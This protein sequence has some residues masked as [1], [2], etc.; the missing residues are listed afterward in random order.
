MTASADGG[1]KL[2][3][4]KWLP[5]PMRW[6]QT[7]VSWGQSWRLAAALVPRYRDRT[8]VH[9]LAAELPGQ[10]D[11]LV[12][13]LPL[14]KYLV[15]RSPELAR[16]ILVTNQDNWAKSAEYDMMAVTFGQGLVTDMDEQRYQRN[17]R[18]VRPIF[19]RT[20]IDQFAEP[21][22]DAAQDA[23]A[24]IQQLADTGQTV[25]IG[26]EMNRLMLDIVARTMFGTDLSGP[27]SKIS[28]TRLLQFYG[29][30]FSSGLSRPLRALSTWVVKHTQPPE[31]RAGSRLSIRAMRALT[32]TSAP[33][34]M[35]E[36]RGMERAVDSLIADHRSGRISRKDNLLGLLMAA[37]DPETGHRYSDLEIRDEL[38]TFIGAGM[39]TSATAMTWMWA[40]LAQ[41][42]QVRE[43]LYEELD[44]VLAGRIP[45]ADDV[46]KLVW[47]KAVFLEAM[48]IY[49]PVIGLT[50]VAKT[51]DVLAGYRVPAGT[52]VVVSVHGVHYNRRVWDRAEQFDPSR[53]LPENMTTERRHASLAFSAGKRIC[54]AQSFATMEVVLSLAT[55]AQRFRL[56]VTSDEP[57]RRQ[58]S[59]IGSPEQPL[60]MRISARA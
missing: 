25:N 56:D 47:C 9:Y 16:H 48:R 21:I 49:P 37:R 28:L 34:L 6:H 60:R 31:R 4:P 8:L 43:T 57:I 23:A 38:M 44:S 3:P 18:V 59:F 19:A 55:I 35:F 42:P 11:V 32:W 27:I 7:R 40:L 50:R 15:V 52:T 39:E 41:H 1:T 24:R 26:P 46:D 10:D 54:V 12:T 51:D 29:V 53:Y 17:Q 5:A 58:M 13:R 22:T 14:L 36:L 33:H 30:G 20:N 2:Y 45:T